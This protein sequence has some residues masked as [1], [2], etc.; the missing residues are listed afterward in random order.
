MYF[1]TTAMRTFDFGSAIFCTIARHAETSAGPVVMDA[2]KSET[3]VHRCLASVYAARGV[4][5]RIVPSG[6]LHVLPRAA[7]ARWVLA[8]RAFRP[9]PEAEAA[10]VGSLSGACDERHL[11][12]LVGSLRVAFPM[13]TICSMALDG[14]V[15]LDLSVSD[16][17]RM[18]VKLVGRARR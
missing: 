15:A 17:G 14:Q 6:T 2:V 1:P 4:A 5:Y 18:L 7:N 3:D 11:A 12:E 10:V 13:E 9:V 16:R 8:H